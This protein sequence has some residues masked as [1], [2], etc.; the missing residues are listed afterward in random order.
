[1]NESENLQHLKAEYKKKIPEMMAQIGSL[2]ADAAESDDSISLLQEAHRLTHALNGTSG[3]IGF[4]D[5]SSAVSALEVALRELIRMR[6]L[7]SVPSGAPYSRYSSAS[8]HPAD[9]RENPTCSAIVNVLVI[10]DDENFLNTVKVMGQENLV[11]VIPAWDKNSALEAARQNRLNAAI[12]DIIL[13][14]GQNSFEIAHELR[15]LPNYHSLPIGFIS[16][17][18][19]VSQRIA[20]VH[21]GASLFLDKPLNSTAFQTAVRRLVPP[22]TECRPRILVIDDDEDFLAHISMMLSSENIEVHTRCSAANI[23]EDAADV[24]PDLILLDVIMDKISG[25]DACRVLRSTEA[26]RD[27]PVLMLTVYGNRKMLVQSFACGADDF[28]EKPIIKEE[29]M[30]RIKLRLDRMKMYHERADID[31]LTGL[32]TRRPFLELFKMR[33]SEGIRFNKPVS[34]CLLDLDNFKKIN[35]TYGHLAGDRVLSALGLLLNSRFRTMD[36]RGR[37]GGE[38]FAVVFYGETAKTSKMIIGRVLEEFGKM[39]FTG[40]HGEEFRVTFSAGVSTFPA[41]GRT[42][43]DLF[44][45]VDKKLY[46]AKDLGRNTITI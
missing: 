33:L 4:L 2:L 20:A 35:D 42:P 12:I 19:S 34:L 17:D 44:R 28:V 22:E 15:R 1:M 21:A 37:W 5:V 7:T 38:E 8:R 40:D 27:V 23:V 16:I 3:T 26:W 6:R 46:A 32:P 14:E 11:N 31:V 24:N 29:L 36:I 30:A 25:H 43:E 9:M 13:G 18:T 41:A 10:D 45:H 39:V